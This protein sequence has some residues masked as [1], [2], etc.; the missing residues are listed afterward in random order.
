MLKLLFCFVFLALTLARPHSKTLVNQ[1]WLELH[2]CHHSEDPYIEGIF[3]NS[4]SLYF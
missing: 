2:S 4:I 1:G 3:F